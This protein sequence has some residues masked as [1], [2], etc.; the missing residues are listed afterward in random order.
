MA[1]QIATHIA[2]LYVDAVRQGKALGEAC[3]RAGV[4]HVIISAHVSCQSTIGIPARHYDSK[5][6]I[7]DYLR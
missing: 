1:A 6:E 5:A 7:Y 2:W 4:P 3:K